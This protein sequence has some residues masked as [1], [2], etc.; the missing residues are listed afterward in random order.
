MALGEL[1]WAMLR[2]ALYS[3][4][5]LCVMAGLGYVGSPWAVLCFPGAICVSYAFGATGMAATTYLRSW[6]DFDMISLAII[7]LFLFSATFFPLSVFPGWLQV[8]VRC[9]PLYQGVA[10]LRGLDLGLLDWALLGHVAYLLVMG[11]VA[12]MVTTRRLARLLLP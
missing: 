4:A 10:L 3:A 8:V 1:T 6:Q 5:F 2:G 11:T 9:S 12:L 7:P